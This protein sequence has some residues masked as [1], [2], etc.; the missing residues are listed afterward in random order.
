MQKNL[1]TY[2]YKRKKK[3]NFETATKSESNNKRAKVHNI[4]NRLDIEI[5]AK[6]KEL[7]FVRF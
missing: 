4:H 5:T 1:K 6:R 3:K 7:S 2:K